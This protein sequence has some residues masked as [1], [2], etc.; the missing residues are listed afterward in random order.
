EVPL[1]ASAE[2]LLDRQAIL[3]KRRTKSPQPLLEDALHPL[4]LPLVRTGEGVR[5]L[6]QV[7]NRSGP[8]RQSPISWIEPLQVVDVAHQVAPA[9]LMHTRI[10]M[11]GRVEVADEHS[12]EGV[13]EDFIDHVFDPP[14]P[15][16]VL[17]ARG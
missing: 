6:I 9:P 11:V 4:A 12:V 13:A 7:V 10:V 2:L 8:A 1:D 17:G 3:Q 14:T 15:Q 16:K 5:L